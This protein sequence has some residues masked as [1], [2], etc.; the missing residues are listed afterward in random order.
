LKEEKL[1]TK[2]TYMKTKTHK[3]CSR[4]FWTFLP[5]DVKIDPYNFELYRFKVKTFFETQCT[6]KNLTV[7]LETKISNTKAPDW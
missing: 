4:V 2:Q 1:I 7:F 6:T 3:L 5:N